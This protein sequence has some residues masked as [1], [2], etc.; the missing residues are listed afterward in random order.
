M[1]KPRS[2]MAFALGSSARSV[3]TCACR[4]ARSSAVRL[5]SGSSGSAS[6]GGTPVCCG[7]VSVRCGSRPSPRSTTSTRCSRSWRKNTSA[8]SRRTPSLS[9]ATTACA[10]GSGMRPARRSVIAPEASSVH[11]L[12]R[13]ATSPGRSSKS[14]PAALERA[15]PELELLGV[16]AEQA[17]VAGARA[18]GDAGADRFDQ[19]GD[20]VVRR[21]RRGGACR[22]P[23]ARC[24]SGGRR[25]RRGRPSRPG[26]SWCRPPGS[27]G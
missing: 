24:R 15:P 21:A 14:R 22:P 9:R 13:A 20:A 11:R 6:S 18:G 12:P 25:S 8:P 16:V 19:A 17:E 4:S 10:S 26:G 2:R 1:S 23:R 5:A 27:A 7:S 3:R